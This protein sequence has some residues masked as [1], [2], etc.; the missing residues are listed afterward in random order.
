MLFRSLAFDAAEDRLTGTCRNAGVAFPMTF[1]RGRPVK[2]PRRPRPQTPAA[3]FPYRTQEIDFLAADGSRLVGTLTRPAADPPHPA[4]ILS[5]W[6]GR[7]DRNQ[8][9][10]GHQPLAV[11]ADALTRRGLATLRYDKRGVGASSGEFDNTTIADSAADLTLATAFLRDQDGI[12]PARIG[13][14]GHSEGGHISAD[15]AAADPAIAFC[16]LLTPSGVPEE[17]MFETELF[18]AAIAVGGVPLHPERTIRLA[19]AIT[20]A[21]RTA[22]SGEAAAARVRDLLTREAEAGRFPSDGIEVR[23]A[24][25]ASPWRRYWWNY[26]HTASLG[27]LTCP[28]LAVFAGCDLQTPPRWHAPNVRAAL[29]G[30]PRARI[31]ELAG[32][33]HFLQPAI[34]GAPSEYADIDQ[35]LAP[36]ALGTVC[37]WVVAAALFSG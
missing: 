23:A 1:A 33:N 15:A 6:Y 30:H 29:A 8:A 37:D 31:V 9:K 24:L 35:T 2:P 14:I 32:L 3:P 27:S 17:D 18:R 11:W 19:R 34:T 5:S 26:D 12:D 10:A 21:G 25:V 20:E 36:E 16:V 13:L 28:V 22:P 4:V 7:A